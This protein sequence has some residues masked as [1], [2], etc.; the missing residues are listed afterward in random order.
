MS[1]RKILADKIVK[2]GMWAAGATLLGLGLGGCEL[3]V[4]NKDPNPVQVQLEK[5]EFLLSG[6]DNGE[7]FDI[8]KYFIGEGIPYTDEAYQIW[9]KDFDKI[10]E[11]TIKLVFR[12]YNG[13]GIIDLKGKF[14]DYF[15]TM[16]SKAPI[17]QSKLHP[18][19][20]V[21]LER[22]FR[23]EGVE[24]GAPRNGGR[25]YRIWREDFKRINHDYTGEFLSFRD[26]NGNGTIDADGDYN[27]DGKIN[28]KDLIE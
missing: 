28:Y 26:Y 12:D 17:I 13:N 22:N 1:L 11:G 20:Y 4:L 18:W 15:R 19:D 8:A 16:L 3:A 25:V 7:N 9:K 27:G 21:D 24:K 5:S 6:I 14:E 10:N 2:P 23:G